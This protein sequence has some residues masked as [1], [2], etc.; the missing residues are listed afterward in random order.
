MAAVYTIIE[1]WL[2]A[3][4]PNTLRGQVMSAYMAVNFVAYGSAQYLLTAMDPGGF[5]LFSLIAIIIAVSLVPL[6]L[7][8]VQ[9]PAEI[10]PSRLGLR[11]L[12]AISPLGVAGCFT[13]GLINGAF[14]AMG[15][16]YARAIDPSPG[17]IA[18]FMMVTVLSG[19]LL[20]FPMGHLSDRFDRR[21]VM[22]GLTLAITAASLALALSGVQST[23]VMIG[24]I[25]LYGGVAYSLYPISLAHANDFMEPADLVSAAA[26][27][28]LCYGAGAV[29]GPILAALAMG[30]FGIGGLFFYS[31]VVGLALAGFAVYRM[32]RREAPPAAEKASFVAVPQTTPTVSE[33]DPRSRP[34]D[35]E[36]QL[37]FDFY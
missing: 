22:L 20:Q 5:Q 2:N 6:S 16:V 28:L 4:A 32:G 18:Q 37:A 26:G 25:C 19:F 8:R 24:L 11:H 3:K 35:E 27:L 15:P 34:Q 17:W 33:L 14:N 29:I 23:A 30:R 1:S 31:A 21:R 13:A 7:I 36:E 12:I 9:T 10:Q